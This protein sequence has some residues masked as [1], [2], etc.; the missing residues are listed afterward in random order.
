MFLAPS[1]NTFSS[2]RIKGKNAF[3]PLVAINVI[4]SILSVFLNDQSLVNKISQMKG[5]F[6]Q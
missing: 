1:P 3:E 5:N 6:F 2:G 4:V